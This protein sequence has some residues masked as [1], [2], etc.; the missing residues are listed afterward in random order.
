MDSFPCFVVIGVAAFIIVMILRGAGER[1][2]NKQKAHAEYQQALNALRANPLDPNL[3]Q[4]T[5]MLG[6]AY[7][8]LTRDSK[9]VT[10]YDEMAIMNDINAATASAYMQAQQ[11][12]P[13]AYHP[14]QSSITSTLASVPTIAERLRKLDDL[15]AQGLVSDDEYTARRT[16]ILDEV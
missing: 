12:A 16:R 1:E 15:K 7:S 3:K 2:R 11:H 8:N 6:R 5:L 13:V 10:V 14:P 4:H 9:G